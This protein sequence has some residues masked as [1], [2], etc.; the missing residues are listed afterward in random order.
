MAEIR[1]K[2]E[3]ELRFVQGSGSGATWATASAPVS[4]YAGFVTDWSFNSGI[5]SY[6]AMERGVPSHHKL[7]SK[8]PIDGTFTFQFTGG[9]PSALTASGASLPLFHFEWRQ[10]TPEVSTA[11]GSGSYYQLYGVLFEKLAI[12]E[13]DQGNTIQVTW[14]ALAMNGPTGSGYLG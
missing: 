10:K 6:Q 13:A 8:D 14:K 4:G 3:G 2:Q 9:M 11:V 7:V 5:K 12:K 1:V